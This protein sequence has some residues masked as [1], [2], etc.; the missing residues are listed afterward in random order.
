MSDA[1]LDGGSLEA[2]F[3]STVDVGGKFRVKKSNDKI[4]MISI[5]LCV[6]RDKSYSIS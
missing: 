5:R 4:P 3:D 6:S 1:F 2:Y